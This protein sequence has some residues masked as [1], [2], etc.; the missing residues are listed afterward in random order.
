MQK[1]PLSSSHSFITVLPSSLLSVSHRP[2]SSPGS[3]SL[4]PTPLKLLSPIPLLPA[5]SSPH[6]LAPFLRWRD[7]VVGMRHGSIS[8][9]VEMR[10]WQIQWWGGTGE[11]DQAPPPMRRQQRRLAVV[12]SGGPSHPYSRKMTRTRTRMGTVTR[13][14]RRRRRLRATMATMTRRLR[15]MKAATSRAAGSSRVRVSWFLDF[16]L[17]FL[18]I[19]VCGWRKHLDYFHVRVRHPHA[20]KKDFRRPL[21]AC[22]SPS[23]LRK[24]DSTLWKN[25]FGSS[26][27]L[28]PLRVQF[29][30]ICW[31][32]YISLHICNIRL[33]HKIIWLTKHVGKLYLNPYNTI[34]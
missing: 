31:W 6:L 17:F 24:M 21:G 13:W 11:T 10:R 27:S 12:A 20:K 15:A 16:I 22:G 14:R 32:L 2:L 5:S 29:Q 7:P 1:S 9:G 4:S 19:F 34:L 26:G 8:G 30:H 28:Q 33:F 23:R 25:A 3:L 18:F